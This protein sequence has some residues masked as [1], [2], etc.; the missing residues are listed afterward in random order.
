V[1]ALRANDTTVIQ[2]AC[3]DDRFHDNPLVTGQPGI[4][5]HAG[6]PLAA[7]NGGTCHR[8]RPRDL[9]AGELRG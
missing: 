8:T 2:D 7:P 4:R 3:N 5:F 6:R 1:H 9:C